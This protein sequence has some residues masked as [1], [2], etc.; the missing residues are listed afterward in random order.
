ADGIGFALKGRDIGGVDLDH[1]RDPQSMAIEPWADNYVQQ[2]PGAY[3]EAT[4][5]GTGL[6]VIGTSNLHLASKFKLDHGNGSAVEFF[7]NSTHYLTLS[8]NEIGRCN[9]LPP[10]GDK[11]AALAAQLGA[12]KQMDFDAVPHVND[13]PSIV[14]DLDFVT[15]VK[16]SETLPAWSFA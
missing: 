14:P 16:K 12:P 3:L 13:A 10:I 4:V 6:R 5:S 1:C 8:C 2:F 11:M 15:D 7:S 9:G